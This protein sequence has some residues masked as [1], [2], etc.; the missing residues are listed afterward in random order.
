VSRQQRESVAADTEAI[1][2]PRKYRSPSGRVITLAE[3]LDRVVAATRLHLPE[4]TL[5]VYPE[6]DVP[7]RIQV[8][9]ETTLQ[10]TA[11]LA[12]EARDEVVALNFASATRPG[13]G[14]RSGAHAQEESL[15]RASGLVASL[16]AAA[17]F[18][19]FH[20]AQR[21]ARYSDRVIY[22]P[23]YRCFVTTPVPY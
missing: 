16:E 20:R 15:A 14:F 5:P 21:D 23:A 9:G 10:A 4:E 13:G 11:R 12:G 18:Y 22:S 17:E 6:T 1:L 2:V 8:T 3:Q 19:T 7:C